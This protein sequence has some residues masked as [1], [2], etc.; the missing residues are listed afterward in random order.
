MACRRAGKRV[1]DA[2][3]YDRTRRAPQMTEKPIENRTW[4]EI[5]IETWGIDSPL[6]QTLIAT[7]HANETYVDYLALADRKLKINHAQTLRAI[8]ARFQKPELIK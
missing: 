8:P 2:R 6:I 5:A 3:E 7:G 4:L 1:N